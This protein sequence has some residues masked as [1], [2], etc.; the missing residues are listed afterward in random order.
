MMF[1]LIPAF[2][3]M[4]ALAFMPDDVSLWLRWA[5]YII[6]VLGVLPSFC[7]SSTPQR[8]SFIASKVKQGKH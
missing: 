4:L 6:Q 5:M 2:S 8:S 3:G 1:S 7:E